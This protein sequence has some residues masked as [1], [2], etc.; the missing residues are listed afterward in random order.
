M[1]K[2][3][4]QKKANEKVIYH[5]GK[6]MDELRKEELTTQ[7]SKKGTRLRNCQAWVYET[8]NYYVLK[9]YDTFIACMNKHTESVYDALRYEYGFTHTSAQHI[10]KFDALTCYGGYK[11]SYGNTRYTW[12]DI[13]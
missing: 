9:S 12:R 2:K 6:A 5:F 3:E 10:S 13:D 7:R 4:A 11:S 1:S 8:E